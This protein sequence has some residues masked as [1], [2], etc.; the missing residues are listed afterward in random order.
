[1]KI[2]LVGGSRGTGAQIAILAQQAGHE[3][4]VLSRS[5]I[6]SGSGRN[7]VGNALDPAVAAEAVSGADAVVIT[8]GGAKSV[9]QQRTAVTRSIVSAMQSAGVK[10][11]IVQSSLGAGGSA[12][13]LPAPFGFITKLLLAKPLADHESQEAIVKQSTLDW[14]I[15][16]PTGLNDKQPTGD[17]LEL[18]IGDATKLKGSIP[19]ADVAACTLR[20]L[21]DNS[22]IGKALGISSR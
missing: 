5:A 20:A 10:R 13:Q 6:S 21:N 9:A 16:R 4:T 7:I 2:T 8:V 1:M 14:T 19:R 17:W 11:L 18:E 12:S 22:T 15:L 3:V